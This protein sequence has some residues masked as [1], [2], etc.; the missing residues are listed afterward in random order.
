[1]SDFFSR[2]PLP[3]WGIAAYGIVTAACVAGLGYYFQE[4]R[5]LI[6]AV[7]CGLFVSG[8]AFALSWA[9]SSTSSVQGKMVVRKRPPAIV[10][11]LLILVVFGAAALRIGSMFLGK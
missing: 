11:W 1:M 9:R 6:A 3:E 5:P 8:I 7:F 10:G 4:R 2:E